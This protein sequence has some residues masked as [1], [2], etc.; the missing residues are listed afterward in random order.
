MSFIASLVFS[1]VPLVA[2]L[3]PGT[4][5]IILTVAISSIA[6]LAFP[7]SEEELRHEQEGE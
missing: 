1:I 7:V 5:T 3:S 2:S 6:A 4:R